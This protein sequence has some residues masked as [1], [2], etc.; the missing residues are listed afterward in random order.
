MPRKPSQEVIDAANKNLDPKD[1]LNAVI[2]D[3]H[4]PELERR[5]VDAGLARYVEGD[6]ND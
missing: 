4:D 2:N 1:V 6:H 3:M 5:L